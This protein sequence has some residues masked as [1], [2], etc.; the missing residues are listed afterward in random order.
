MDVLRLHS[1]RS[2]QEKGGIF[3]LLFVLGLPLY[4]PSFFSMYCNIDRSLTAIGQKK[5]FSHSLVFTRDARVAYIG[6]DRRVQVRPTCLILEQQEPWTK[7]QVIPKAEPY[8][9]YFYKNKPQRR[10]TFNFNDDLCFGLLRV[11]YTIIYLCAT[12]PSQDFHKCLQ[13][14]PIIDEPF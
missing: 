9:Q 4:S 7:P 13:S 2:C 14:P 12:W 6:T 1:F 8:A 5:A 3:V 11:R 10:Q